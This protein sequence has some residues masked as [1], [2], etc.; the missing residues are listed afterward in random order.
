MLQAALEVEVE[1]FAEEHATMGDG[2]SSAMSI[3]RPAPS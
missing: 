1:A 2:E 3:S